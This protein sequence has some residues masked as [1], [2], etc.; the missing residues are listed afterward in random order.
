MSAS[1]TEIHKQG[2]DDGW[3]GVI[4]PS[5]Q[6]PPDKGRY[7]IYAG[8]FCPF[9][10]R[11]LIVRELKGLTDYID[12]SIV[13]AYPKGDDKGWPGW[14]FDVEGTYEA[15]T[16]DNL[17]GSK[18]LHEVYFR[19]DKEYKGRY[20][21]PVLWDRKSETIVNNVSVKTIS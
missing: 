3:H 15:A 19:A 13:K 11:A 2:T 18:Y 4:S 16:K 14:A 5:S 9:A 6:F 17:F 1:N 8:L 10:Q 7:H 20:S 21:V 12:L